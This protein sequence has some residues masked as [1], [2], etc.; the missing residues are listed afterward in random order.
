MNKLQSYAP[1]VVRIG[2][3]LVVFWFG[4]NQLVDPGA[5]VRLL[6]DYTKALPFSPNGLILFNGTFEVLAAVLLLLG[7]YTRLVAMIVTIHLAHIVVVVGYGAT[8]VRDFGLFLA[9]LSVF[10]FGRDRWSVDN[11][12]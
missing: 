4:V 11:R 2:V 7:F 5:W 10:F 3:G 6:P 1:V 8:G 12:M 9:S